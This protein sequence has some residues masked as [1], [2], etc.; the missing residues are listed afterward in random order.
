MQRQRINWQLVFNL[1]I[2]IAVLLVPTWLWM[3]HNHQALMKRQQANMTPVIMI[4]GSSASIDRFNELVR[5]LNRVE[6]HQHTILK[7]KVMNDGTI[8][9]TGKLQSGDRFPIIV[10]GFQNNHDGYRNIKQQTE[11]FDQAMRD[12]MNRYNFK[13]V[14]AFGHSNGGLIWTRWLELD[15]PDLQNQITVSDLM[16]V[17]TPYN[18]DETSVANRT[19]MLNDLIKNRSQL[20]KRLRV[21]VVI[22]TQSYTSDGLVPEASAQAAKYIFQKQ[23]AAYS[24]VTVSGTGAQHSNLP[25]N[26]QIIR[27]MQEYLLYKERLNK[28]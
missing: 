26:K 23:V 24:T 4:P 12:L 3:R 27:L 17:G 22:G 6:R 15:Y 18:F 5:N 19:Q 20:P 7:V 11:L 8:K 16:T 10:V 14:R 21:L 28:H 13:T 25:Q 9:Y 2:V 1:L